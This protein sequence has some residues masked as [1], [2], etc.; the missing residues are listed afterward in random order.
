MLRLSLILLFALTLCVGAMPAQDEPAPP[1]EPPYEFVSGIISELPAGKI[2]V[3]RAVLGKPPENRTFTITA[4]TKIEGKL[5]LRARVTVGFKLADEG[6]PVAVRI[7][8]RPQTP[9]SKS[10]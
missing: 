5:A 3:N 9:G 7:I 4:D 10:P 2:V 6:E 1:S 8:V